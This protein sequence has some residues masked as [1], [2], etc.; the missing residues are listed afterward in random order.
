MSL[1]GN[2][3][4]AQL[5]TLLAEINNDPRGVGYAAYLPSSDYINLAR[6]LNF[7]RDG[8]TACP[9]NNVVG[10]A[11]GAITGATNA[12]PIS[13]A[14][15]AHGLKTGNAVVV[16]G[17][18]GNTNADGTWAITKVDAND[19]TLNGSA[20]NAAYTSGGIWMQAVRVT[21]L[22]TEAIMTTIDNRDW[23]G[24]G[25]GAAVVGNDLANGQYLVALTNQPSGQV[26]MTNPDGTDTTVAKNLKRCVGNTHGSQTDLTALQW[27]NAGRGEL[28]LTLSGSVGSQTINGVQAQFSNLLD[29]FDVRAA[30]TGSY[31]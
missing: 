29:Q 25:N 21:S 10:T 5:T 18:G 12:T 19:F 24:A 15:A 7:I 26:S 13:I 20:G 8:A 28:V 23:P 14:S 4:S 3:S 1:Y 27:R 11:D 17:V 16:T 22:S 6:L 30:I 2:L 9:V 31:S